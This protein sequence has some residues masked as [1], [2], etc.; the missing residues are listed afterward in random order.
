[1]QFLHLYIYANHIVHICTKNY[2][3][4]NKYTILSE[5][6]YIKYTNITCNHTYDVH[7]HI[8]PKIIIMIV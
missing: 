2:S 3:I 7:I 8:Y 4:L 6:S 5:N 1:M